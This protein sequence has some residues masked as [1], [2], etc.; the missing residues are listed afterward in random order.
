MMQTL[1]KEKRLDGKKY[2][3][4]TTTKTGALYGAS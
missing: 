3:M 2:Y 4:D 1:D